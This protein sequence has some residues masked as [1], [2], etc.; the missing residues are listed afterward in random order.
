M[1]EF[2]SQTYGKIFGEAEMAECSPAIN[3]MLGTMLRRA[4]DGSLPAIL[5]C[6]KT[7]MKDYDP[8]YYNKVALK[9]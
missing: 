9:F 6:M 5:L 1:D 3:R 8:E 7:M 2:A 4:G